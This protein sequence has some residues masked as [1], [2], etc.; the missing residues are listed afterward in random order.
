MQSGRYIAFASLEWMRQ[1]SV[2]TFTFSV[3]LQY[4][5]Q[6]AMIEKR[7]PKCIQYISSICTRFLVQEEE[8]SDVN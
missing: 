7:V 6:C 1:H 2:S 8:V 4:T 5:D 3:R